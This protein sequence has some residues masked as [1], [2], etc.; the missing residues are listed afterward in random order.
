MSL[1]LYLVSGNDWACNATEA[2][3]SSS[4]TERENSARVQCDRCAE[5]GYL[6]DMTLIACEGLFCSTCNDKILNEQQADA[7]QV[8]SDEGREAYRRDIGRYPEED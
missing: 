6:R 4:L 1:M 5:W 3:M 8:W 2:P 7:E